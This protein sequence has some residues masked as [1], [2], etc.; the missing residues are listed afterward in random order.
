MR[1]ELM[2]LG[3]FVF[4][5]PAATFQEMRRTAEYRWE[6]LDRLGRPPA[7]QWLGPGRETISLSGTILPVRRRADRELEALKAE[8][9][10]GEPLRL[11][12]GTGEIL[13]LWSVRRIAETG[14]HYLPG[15]VPRKVEFEVDLVFY[16]EDAGDTAIAS[17]APVATVPQAVPSVLAS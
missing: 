11:M 7:R 12:L 10:K 14:S 17:A 16:G 13:G 1:T 2:T 5:V 6:A 15:G 4:G 9:R 3:S 8:A